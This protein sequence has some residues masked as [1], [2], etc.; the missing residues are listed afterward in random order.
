MSTALKKLVGHPPY[1]IQDY[2]NRE[3]RGFSVEN[4]PRKKIKVDE[5]HTPPI[6]TKNV[7][8][9]RNNNSQ[10]KKDFPSRKTVIN[11]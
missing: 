1:T 7:N 8:A 5:E 11:L 9:N 2:F 6:V 4:A 3:I 10:G